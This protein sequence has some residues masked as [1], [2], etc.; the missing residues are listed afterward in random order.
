MSASRRRL[1]IGLALSLLAPI[2]RGQSAQTQI[3]AG[4]TN[5]MAGSSTQTMSDV[6][7]G[8]V[9]KVDKEAKKITLRHGE[10]KGL[11]MPPMT[12]VFQVRDPAMLD[13]VK[14][15]DKVKFK[16]QNTGGTLVITEIEVSK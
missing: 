12:M 8:D 14:P 15:G 9:R 2:A 11:D 3:D 16:A 6:A 4:A 10:L 13:R 7:D 5:H 1:C